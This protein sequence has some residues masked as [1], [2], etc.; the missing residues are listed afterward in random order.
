[1][2]EI[3][4]IRNIFIENKFRI[5]NFIK[6]QNQLHKKT[7]ELVNRFLCSKIIH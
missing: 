4:I 6:I 3:I 1:M 2:T 7:I 5:N